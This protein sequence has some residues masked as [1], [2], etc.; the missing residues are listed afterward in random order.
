MAAPNPV[1]EVGA[2]GEE[3]HADA[4]FYSIDELPNQSIAEMAVGLDDKQAEGSWSCSD[5]T[6]SRRRSSS[7]RACLCITRWSDRVRR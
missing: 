5:A 2:E 7:H 1:D 3:G 4:F 6:C